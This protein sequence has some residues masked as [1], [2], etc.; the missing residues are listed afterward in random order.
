M[1]SGTVLHI[2]DFSDSGG[3]DVTLRIKNYAKEVAG[4][5]GRR[6]FKWKVFVDEPEE[7]LDEIRQV[8]YVLHPTFPNPKRVV[9]ERK[10]AFA[11]ES[12]GWGNFSMLVSVRFKD[13]REERTRHLLD[14][15]RPWPEAGA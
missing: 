10:S 7:K 14:L 3:H 11:L 15:A 8:E 2:P 13:G 9:K 6:W 1:A 4:R 5:A 12:A